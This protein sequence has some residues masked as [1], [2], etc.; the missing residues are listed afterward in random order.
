MQQLCS[1]CLVSANTESTHVS[2]IL[3][4]G[5]RESQHEGKDFLLLSSLAN[6]SA[7]HN[8]QKIIIVQQ[9]LGE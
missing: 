6:P 4:T 7:S 2:P 5:Q 9:R 8:T 3:T 1:L